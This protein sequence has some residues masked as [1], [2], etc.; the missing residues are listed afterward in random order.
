MIATFGQR[1][2]VETSTGEYTDGYMITVTLTE[3]EADD[4]LSRY[5]PASGTSPGVADARPIARV[6]LNEIIEIKSE[7]T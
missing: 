5:D 4:L 7:P 3:A 6:I 1:S 2:Y